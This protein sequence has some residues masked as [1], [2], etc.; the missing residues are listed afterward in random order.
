VHIEAQAQSYA[1]RAWRHALG[2]FFKESG[3]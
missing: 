1:A 2:V 3:F